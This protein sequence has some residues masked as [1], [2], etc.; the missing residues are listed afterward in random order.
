MKIFPML[1]I[2][3]PTVPEPKQPDSTKI[4]GKINNIAKIRYKTLFFSFFS[5][6]FTFTYFF[7]GIVFFVRRNAYARTAIITL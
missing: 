5:P 4:D 3:I 2:L 1:S 6:L 7:L